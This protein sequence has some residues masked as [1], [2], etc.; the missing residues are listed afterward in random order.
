MTLR[1]LNYGNYGIF[2][3]M[4]HAG[5]CPSTVS[6]MLRCPEMNLQTPGKQ[7][8]DTNA[9]ASPCGALEVGV[10]LASNPCTSALCYPTI[11]VYGLLEVMILL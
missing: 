5:F 10:R 2:L 7:T 4:G 9:Q 6:Q 3:I 11:H 1:T 8:V